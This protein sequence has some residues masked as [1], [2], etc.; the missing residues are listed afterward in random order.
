M[1]STPST[2]AF[3]ALQLVRWFAQLW[4]DNRKQSWEGFIDWLEST[5]K[6]LGDR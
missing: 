2:P 4:L 3:W 1:P 6:P 5:G